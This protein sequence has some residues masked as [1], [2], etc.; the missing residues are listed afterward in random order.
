MRQ[1]HPDNPL[2][3]CCDQ[4]EKRFK[5]KS[6]LDR[7]RK[8]H[9]KKTDNMSC[10]MCDF[11]TGSEESLKRHIRRHAN[12]IKCDLCE[13]TSDRIED[14]KKHFAKHHEDQEGTS[15]RCDIC[16]RYTRKD[17]TNHKCC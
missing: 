15:H 6:K 10:Q 16:E 14:V 4:C 11:E 17:I 5:F 1:K 2:E 3:Y 13:Y 12:L 9:E 8:Q 7:H